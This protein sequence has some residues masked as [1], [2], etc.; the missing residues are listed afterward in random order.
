MRALT[1]EPLMRGSVVDRLRRCGKPNCACA[2]D[3]ASRHGG[4]FLTVHLDGRTRALHVR[5]EDEER[6][7][8]AI[9]AYDRLWEIINELT[10]CEL[11]DLSREVRER[12]RSRRR[13]DR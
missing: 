13:K 9:A 1:L 11:S 5:P 3:P 8:N 4:R 2:T 7:R 10:A 12:R 6:V